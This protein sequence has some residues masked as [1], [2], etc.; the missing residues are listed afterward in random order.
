ME[1]H[2]WYWG[3]EGW[4][5]RKGKPLLFRKKSWIMNCSKTMEWWGLWNLQGFFSLLVRTAWQTRA[6]SNSWLP[7]DG[8]NQ[9][10]LTSPDSYLTCLYLQFS[11]LKKTS[12]MKISYF[13]HTRIV[14]NFYWTYPDEK[15][16]K[17]SLDCA[18]FDILQTTVLM[19]VMHLLL[20]MTV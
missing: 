9:T 4:M 12:D 19:Y 18:R 17:T 14:K 1:V 2:S 3:S 11:S 6:I 8:L 13:W 16:E 10:N 15:G 5:I 20:Q 7:F